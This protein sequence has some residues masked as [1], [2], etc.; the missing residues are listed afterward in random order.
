MYERRLK[1]FL[2]MV[3]AAM[4]IVL[5]RLVH[6]QL[7][8]ADDYRRR[9]AQSLV[10][11]EPLPTARG[12]VLDRNNRV[13]AVDEPCYDLCLHYQMLTQDDPRKSGW[14]R[15]ELRRI[16]RAHGVDPARARAIYDRRVQTTW[17]LAEKLSGT[18]RNQMTQAARESIQRIRAWRRRCN[19]GSLREEFEPHPVVTG[20]DEET[21]AGI[22]LRLKDM[23]G[24]A[25]R[26]SS[27]R[28]YPCGRAACHL[29]GRVGPV[30]EG[31]LASRNPG[32][33]LTELQE[34]AL[35]SPGDLIGKGGVEKAC[36]K[37]LRGRRGRRW[38]QRR[39]GKVV[40]EIPAVAGRDVHL[41]L[42][43]ELQQEI[44]AMLGRPGSVVVLDV[45]T[46][47]VLAAVSLPEYDLNTFAEDYTRLSKDL[48]D[49]P[50]LN[51]AVQVDLPPG[52]TVKPAIALAGLHFG[53]L[54]AHATIT[55]RGWLDSPDD[56]SLRCWIYKQHGGRHG[57]LDLVH[58]LEQSCNCFFSTLGRRLTVARQ[59]EWLGRMGFA[60]PPGTGLPE[61]RRCILPD[62][63]SRREAPF[64][65]IGQGGITATPMHVANAMA[66][67]ARGG[68]FR[69]PL[70]VRELKGRQQVRRLP[71]TPEQVELV[72][73][74]MYRVVNVGG[75]TAYR[76][77]HD[78]DIEICG[79]TG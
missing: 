27:A 30:D 60:D 2:T 55:C 64:L 57:P 32:G 9:A 31:E 76:H 12:Q 36:E 4:T 66:T 48:A 73:R 72:Q 29:I 46:G 41:T 8:M 20:L 78:P 79:K 63:R 39:T 65:P 69:S 40:R 70:L 54:D 1:I 33:D 13:L 5:A 14:L 18:S 35:Y 11:D 19:V 45:A 51:R 21:A 42:D 10:Y 28:R 58:A 61:E 74:G 71:V 3:A 24:A 26:P 22:G 52:S 17:D 38:R 53:L 49:P 23:I 56:T 43:V 16:R 50:F 59:V 62:P 15:R 47:E 75:G 68:E 77:A 7:V 6:M 67:I 44:A 37:R 25:I 34:L